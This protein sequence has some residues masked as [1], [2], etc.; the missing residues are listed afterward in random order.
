MF[1]RK[2]GAKEKKKK[3]VKE[4]VGPLWWY[5][6]SQ[7]GVIVDVLQ[8]LRRVECNGVVGGK[9][10]IMIRIFDLATA[11]QKGVAIDNHDSLDSHPELI[12][13]EGYYRSILGVAKDIH[14]QKK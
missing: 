10:V 1:W 13:Y 14:I 9:Q 2:R 5:M 4:I 8:N 11:N 3:A 7:H 12:L 6:V